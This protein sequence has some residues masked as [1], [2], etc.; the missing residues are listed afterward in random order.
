M[1]R[2]SETYK[3]TKLCK[4]WL[5]AGG[6]SCDG[7]TQRTSIILRMALGLS[8]IGVGRKSPTALPVLGMKALGFRVGSGLRDISRQNSVLTYMCTHYMQN[9]LCKAYSTYLPLVSQQRIIIKPLF[10]KSCLFRNCLR[11]LGRARFFINTLV[12]RFIIVTTNLI[13]VLAATIF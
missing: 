7:M 8:C 1:F 2:N 12:T 4:C 10:H 13:V 5:D 9:T 3:F 6:G 11:L